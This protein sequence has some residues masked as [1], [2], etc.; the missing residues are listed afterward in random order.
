[1]IMKDVAICAAVETLAAL[2]RNRGALMIAAMLLCAVAMGASDVLAQTSTDPFAPAVQ[3]GQAAQTSAKPLLSVLG[4]FGLA[5]CVVVGI[6]SKGK[7]PIAWLLAIGFGF[8]LLGIGPGL[9]TWLSSF[10]SSTT[11]T[12][13]S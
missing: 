12:T 3:A 7:F 8:L 10:G 2:S 5:A 1:M 11:S 9:L 13:G 6:F 4:W